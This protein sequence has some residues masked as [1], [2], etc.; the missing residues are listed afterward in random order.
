MELHEICNLCLLALESRYPNCV[1]EM[2]GRL[3]GRSGCWEK[4]CTPGEIS[5]RL[6]LY[7]P[8]IL[9]S[10]ALLVIDSAQ[11]EIYLVEESEEE[12]AF[13][14]Y[15]GGRTPGMSHPLTRCEI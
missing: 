13:R 12:P 6:R 1:L 11:S 10:P 5:T 7:A 3:L 2:N 14:V 9:R 15:C 8:H 4:A